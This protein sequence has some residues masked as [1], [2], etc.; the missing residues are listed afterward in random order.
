MI[1]YQ[2]LT[3]QCTQ[4]EALRQYRDKVLMQNFFG[5]TLVDFYYSGVGESI[6]H[7]IKNRARFA[8]PLIR[9]SLDSIVEKNS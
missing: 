6:A 4:I 8:I 7:F 2:P 3:L 9:K 5:R 1:Y